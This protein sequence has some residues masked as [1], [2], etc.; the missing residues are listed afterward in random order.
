MK[1]VLRCDVLIRIEMV[2]ALPARGA[3]PRIPSDAERLELSVGKL[4]EILLEGG[5]AER[6]GDLIVVQLSVPA[7][8]ADEEAS[9]LVKNVEVRP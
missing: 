5:G 9:S 7:L 1:G 3:G 4:N 2:P 8:R 6:V